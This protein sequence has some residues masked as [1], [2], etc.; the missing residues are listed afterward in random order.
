MKKK[1]IISIISLFILLVVMLPAWGQQLELDQAQE[2]RNFGFWFEKSLTRWQ[3]FRPLYNSLSEVDLYINKK[4]SPGNL[5]V[6]VKKSSGETIWSTTVSG[7]SIPTSGWVE[8]PV[9]PSVSLVPHSS[10]YIHVTSD[11]SSP[12]PD[13]RFFW[14]GK[15]GSD[16]DRGITSVEESWPGYDF[17][18]RTWTDTSEVGSVCFIYKD[19]L[20]A[21]ENFRNLLDA[22]GYP[23]TLIS[24]AD[25]AS[26][27][28]SSYALI[29]A[30]DDTGI[31]YDWGTQEAVRA[32]IA[33]GKK[34]LGLGYGGSCLFQQMGLSINWGHGA[35]GFEDSIYVVD[36]EHQLFDQPYEID[37]PDDRI[38][39]L[40]QEAGRY[41]AE[42]RP[43]LNDNVIFL[44]R[45]PHLRDYYPI[46]K[47]QDHILWGFASSPADMT[48]TGKKLFINTVFHLAVPPPPPL[49][50]SL[51]IED[52]LEGVP[53]NK[54][55]G[56]IGGPTNVT[57]LEIVTKLVSYSPSAKL[58]IPVVLNIPG[59]LFGNPVHVYVRDTTGG[60]MTEVTYDDLGSGRYRVTT[61]LTPTYIFPWL[62]WYYHRQIVW[63]FFIPNSLTPQNI[64]VTAELE[65]PATDPSGSGV[66]KI[67]SPGS[68]HAIIITNRKLLYDKHEDYKVSSL[69][70][71]IF[72][73]AQGPPTSHSP[74]GVVY[75]VDR[76]DT[77]ARNWDNTTVSYSSESTANTVANAI[78]ALI[79]DWHDDATHYVDF[80]IPYYGTFHI[81]V[82]YPTYLLI[83]GDDDIIPFYR[84]NDP[85]NEEQHWGV[86]SATNPAVRSTDHDYYFTDNPYADLGGGTDWQKGNLELSVGRLLGATAGD[87][88]SLLEEGVDW[89]NGRRGGIVMASVAGWELGLE[90]D[91][92]RPGEVADLADVP[93]LLRA[94]GFAVRNDDIPSSE[95]RTIDVLSP[96]EGGNSNWIT[97]FR[98]AANNASGMDLFF[99]GGHNNYDL[100]TLPGD[101]FSPDD[102]PTRYTRFG[103]DHPVAMI[104][105][106]HGGTPV[107]DIDVPGGPDHCM[108]YDLIHEGVRAFIGAS[109]Y[110]YGSP[111]R[112][113][114]CTWG[115]R[116]MQR[117]FINLTSPSGSNSMTLGKALSEAKRDY[118]FGFGNDYAIDALDRKTVTEFNLFGVP[119]AFIFYPH[120]APAE[121]TLDEAGETAFESSLGEILP[122][123]DEGVY[124]Q[125][126]D[127]DVSRY[128]VQKE[129]QDS[130]EYELFS[131]EGGG[132]AIA[133]GLPI[134]PYLEVY[135][136]PLPEGAEIQEVRLIEPHSENIGRYNVPIA[137]VEPWSE[138]GLRYTTETDIDY[139]Y[140]DQENLVR[141]QITQG[142][143]LLTVFP[144]Q[145]NPKSDE[146]WFYKSFRIQVTYEA[147]VTISITDFSLNKT[148]Y[149]V[150][151][152]VEISAMIAN[153]GSSEENLASVLYIKDKFGHVLDK[154]FSRN[155]MVPSGG[156]YRLSLIWEG[157]LPD[158]A[159][160]AEISIESV[161]GTPIAGASGDFSVTSGEIVRLMVP[162]SLNYGETGRFDVAFANYRSQ[163]VK[164]EV[165]LTIQDN[166][167]GFVENL[168]LKHMEV[169]ADN[170]ET[171]SF[172]WDPAAVRGGVYTATATVRVDEQIYGPRTEFF[173]VVVT[174]CEGDLDGD[175]DVDGFDLSVFASEYH[176]MDCPSLCI[177]DVDGNKQVNFDDFILFAEKYGRIGCP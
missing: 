19:D 44:G 151:E 96:Y 88:L 83:V 95:V 126:I 109:G 78:D 131:V 153:V 21:A 13:N 55:V 24:I 57:R 137:E 16:Y 106:C 133:P 102:T 53:V 10:Y 149:L 134:L 60:T 67:L 66:V 150:G 101:S 76:Y 39:Q 89:N 152:P 52:A 20:A 117:F 4:G 129:K 26:T 175:K 122:G 155:F 100:A 68:P 169:K 139:P 59:D 119:W 70:Q 37:V 173:D 35:V 108:V 159:Y 5:I 118:V 28:F 161:E 93:F 72:S 33:S 47:E 31:S 92:G 42:Y 51:N 87:M 145:H 140:P 54:L 147:P 144:I 11:I 46:V 81:P 3:E 146:T 22:N 138:G 9:E 125:T 141:Y 164:A 58:D 69:L 48:N 34:V 128:Q 30:G 127:V 135:S 65:V 12:G 71:R 154:E 2:N 36:T 115:E 132:I 64:T 158:G 82:A 156:N 45:I 90:P 94:K 97:N 162:E 114:K 61:D 120:P 148:R 157:S 73:E 62:P 75:Y 103:I 6:Y 136:L 168:P 143:L 18:F 104:V 142:S 98:N 41:I 7:S 85:Y 160:K 163:A 107:P 110:S 1:G 124:T 17:A 14:S 84:Y 99:I 91:D 23:T 56:D 116:L 77:R 63:R 49:Y 8:I 50:L 80:Y 176:P 111:G 79:E 171:V 166:E 172:S 27:D 177:A 38:V 86:N 167:G 174:R 113:H 130:V 29:I 170:E 25:V 112:L 165:R 105:G 74:P 43:R 32:I 15:T 121:T 123:K 40:Y